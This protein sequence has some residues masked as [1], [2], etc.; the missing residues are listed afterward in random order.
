LATPEWAATCQADYVQQAVALAADVAHLAQLRAT[1]R[2]TL[3]ASLAAFTRGLEDAL[4]GLAHTVA[5]A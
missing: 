3:Q 1:L 5:P 4:M 2:P